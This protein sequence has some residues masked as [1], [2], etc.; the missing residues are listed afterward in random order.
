MINSVKLGVGVVVA[1]SAAVVAVAGAIVVTR[2]PLEESGARLPQ[3]VITVTQAPTG[4]PAP[5]MPGGSGS[6][7]VVRVDPA[8]AQQIIGGAGVSGSGDNGAGHGGTGHGKGP[9]HS[10]S[11][12]PTPSGGPGPTPGPSGTPGDGQN[13]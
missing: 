11:P 4:S 13:G 5:P 3:S 8:P 2:G 9:G 1:A 10:P 7:E 6:S 12:S